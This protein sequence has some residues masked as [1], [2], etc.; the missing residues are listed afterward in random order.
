[1]NRFLPYPLALAALI[2]AAQ[3]P[4]ARAVDASPSL[5]KTAI[6]YAAQ[7]GDALWRQ[8][9]TAEP[10]PISGCHQLLGY[11]LALCEARVH[12][13]RLERLFA[14]TRQM[15]DQDP[16]SKNW[17][18]LRWCWR[19]AGVTDTNA[20]EF[21]MHDAL[22]MQIRHGDWLPP[23]AKQELAALV[24]LGVEGCLRHRVPTDYTNIAL[25]N[26]GN[27][28]VLGQRLDRAD[29]AREGCRR[30]A[31][32][33]ARTAAF[34]IHE[35]CSPTYYGTDLNGLL[36]IHTYAQ[37]ERERRQADAL[38]QLFW[39]DI[40]ANWFPAAQRLGGCH[41]R[42]YDYLHGLGGLD[43]HLWI[44]GWLQSQSAG[45]EERRE[46]WN[47]EWSPP[48]SLVEMGRRQFPRWVRQHWGI[49]PAESRS[50]MLYR[51]IALSCCGAG[52]G[53]QDTTL[54][55]DLPGGRELARCYFIPDGREDPYGKK[56]IEIGSARHPKA[57]HMQPF[58]AGAQRSCDALGLVIYRDRDMAGPEVFHVQS[59]FVLRRTAD[60]W[61][62]GKHLT[63]PAG[64]AEKP[65]EVPIPAGGSLVLRYGSAAVGV[66]VPWSF[67]KL[68]RPRS[69]APNPK[70]SQQLAGG[71]RSATTGSRCV[72]TPIDPEG[73]T[74][75][76][77]CDPFGV[78]EMSVPGTPGCAARPGANGYHPSGMSL[79]GANGCHPS[80]MC[81]VDDGNAW[82]CLRLTVDHGRSTDLV[83]T[84]PGM[85]PADD[86]VAGTAF[87]VRVGSELTRDA[88]FDAWRKDFN[89]SSRRVTVGATENL[90]FEVPGKDGPLSITVGAPWDQSARMQLVP[91]PYQG[92]LEVNGKELG[93][94]LLTAVE[95]LCSQPP[96]A[97]PLGSMNVPA[98]KAFFWEAESGLVLP[99]MAVGEDAEASGHRYVGQAPSPI[100]QPSGSVTWS[101]AIERPARYWLWAR[102]RSDNGNQGA[103][104]FQAIG[105][106]GAVMP[107]ATWIPRAPGTWQW[108]PLQFEGAKSPA[109]LDLGKGV[110]HIQLQTRRSGT[111]IDRLM[112]TADPRERP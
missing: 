71:K 44:H 97:G 48:P 9:A 49:L 81:L 100:G 66:R 84:S 32:I 79:A 2:L 4:I 108:Q 109:G 103:F 93:L 30:L 35:F 25:L 33:V 58:W 75:G 12:P 105:E 31:A 62:D 95:P 6:E 51:D 23:G 61:L 64:T 83:K 111:M 38:L 89:E 47:E 70:G 40:A 106:D 82:N 45:S 24:R 53:P 77:R 73:V 72:R 68:E 13:E 37:A 54:A 69:S 63:M 96:G 41:S 90:H 14:L 92:V 22:L 76:T 67:V 91:K 74:A 55:V 52:Y 20:V 112:L 46:P 88:D 107:P 60:I 7:R 19:D 39:T 28:I 59:H 85:V 3:A 101:L 110:Y 21:S 34:G 42:S 5:R 57:L 78:S 87:W 27:L 102:V 98:G 1:M 17:G 36:L 86:M 8:I 94:P 65:A 29:A 104:S 11:A 16:H 15:Q 56:T 26:A 80:G 43:W 99:G 50:Q 18:N 10:R